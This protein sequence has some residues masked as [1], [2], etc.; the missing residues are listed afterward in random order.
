MMELR[1]KEDSLPDNITSLIMSP[2]ILCNSARQLYDDWRTISSLPAHE[3]GRARQNL[4]S[5]IKPSV[6]IAMETSYW[7]Y[8]SF[9]MFEY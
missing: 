7:R 9:G 6:P 1:R 2:I 8:L 5:Q 3:Q 4:I